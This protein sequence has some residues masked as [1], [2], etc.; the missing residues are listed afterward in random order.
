MQSSLQTKLLL[1][2]ARF[3]SD[4]IALPHNHNSVAEER[5]MNHSD[6][7]AEDKRN[8]FGWAGEGEWGDGAEQEA[9]EVRLYFNLLSK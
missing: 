9:P 7:N 2:L 1:N 3:I 6:K 5:G 8:T 4:N